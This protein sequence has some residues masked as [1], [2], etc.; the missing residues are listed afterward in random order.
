MIRIRRGVPPPSLTRAANRQTPRD[1]NT[2][3][4]D[5]AA[6]ANGNKKFEDKHYYA[7]DNVKRTLLERQ[8]YKCCYCERR[9]Q[10]FDLQVEH[11]RPKRGFRQGASQTKD[12]HPGYYWLAYSWDNLLL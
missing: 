2:Y 12:E 3:D 4:T 9:L 11:F 7:S 1:C 6:Y 10:K 5:A 8:H